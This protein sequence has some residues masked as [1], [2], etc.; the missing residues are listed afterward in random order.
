MATILRYLNCEC[1]KHKHFPGGR[2]HLI[3]TIGGRT[4]FVRR[5]P[6]CRVQDEAATEAFRSGQ[7]RPR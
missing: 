5:C 3:A 7:H 2:G 6:W 1:T 4:Y